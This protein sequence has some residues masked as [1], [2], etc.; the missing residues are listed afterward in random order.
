MARDE[1]KSEVE[2]PAEVREQI[3]LAA[4]DD[5]QVVVEDDQSIVLRGAPG[6]A[7]GPTT[8]TNRPRFR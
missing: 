4:G 3:G 7:R 2:L 1:K 5:F 8:T 6:P